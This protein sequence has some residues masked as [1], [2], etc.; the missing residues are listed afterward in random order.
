MKWNNGRRSKLLAA[1]LSGV[2]LTMTLCVPTLS[3]QPESGAPKQADAV[4]TFYLNNISELQEATEIQTAIRNILSPEAKIYFVPRQNAVIIRTTPDQMLLAQKLIT[5][6]DRP[7]KTYRLTYTINE[8]D[9]GKR[10]GTQ[11]FSMLVVSGQRTTLKQGSKV[12]V[13]TGSYNSGSAGT[14]NQFTYLD[15]GLNLDATLD[16]SVNGVRLRS[17]TEQSSIAAEKSTVGPDD[18]IVRQT[19]LEG[20]SILTP[21]KSLTLGSVDVPGSTRHLDIEV[22]MEVVR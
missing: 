11:H 12:P 9:E 3:A 10:I 13:E 14:Q 21:G 19:V 1:A 7:R 20:T 17:K 22:T 18:P 8:S 16:E 4:Q 5:E 6:L 15:I 2:A